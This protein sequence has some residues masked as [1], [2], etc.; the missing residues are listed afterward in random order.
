MLAIL[1]TAIFS[2]S[3]HE[4]DT[5]ISQCSDRRNLFAYTLGRLKIMTHPNGRDTDN[6]GNDIGQHVIR[7][8]DERQRVRYVTKDK[9][10]EEK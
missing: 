7:V 3:L 5:V 2:L 6:K 8:A 4:T 9:F 10:D 1:G